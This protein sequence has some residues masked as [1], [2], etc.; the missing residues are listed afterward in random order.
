MKKSLIAL[1]LL[2]LLFVLNAHVAHAEECKPI[3]GGGK[4]SEQVCDGEKKVAPKKEEETKKPIP[5]T[6]TARPKASPTPIKSGPTP[7]KSET[8]KGG[9][10]VLP[11]SQQKTTP[12][13][14]PEMLGLLT[15]LPAGALGYYLRKKTK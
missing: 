9:L 12:P 14:G 2:T 5:P 8:T 13:T 7:I 3:Y 6:P 15:L 11:P 10:P 4:T 1:I